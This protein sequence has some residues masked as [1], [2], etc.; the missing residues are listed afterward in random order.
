MSGPWCRMDL[1]ASKILGLFRWMSREWRVG[2]E[3]MLL[4]YVKIFWKVEGSSFLENLNM[5]MAV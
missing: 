4:L 3:W 2:Y 1:W 5:K